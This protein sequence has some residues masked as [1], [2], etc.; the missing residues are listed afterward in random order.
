[1]PLEQQILLPD[2][3]YGQTMEE[4]K[5]YLLNL[6]RRCSGSFPLAAQREFNPS[7]VGTD[8]C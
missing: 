7:M 6:C 8:G 3:L 1:M 2:T 4:F 5:K